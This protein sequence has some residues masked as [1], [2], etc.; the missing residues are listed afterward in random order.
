MTTGIQEYII[1]SAGILTCTSLTTCFYLQVVAMQ[2]DMQKQVAMMVAVRV[3]K[4]G[5][6]LE[7]SLGR[8]MEKAVKANA[9]ALWAHFQ[10]ENAKLEKAS[11]ERTQQLSNMISNCLNKDL[12]AILEK[13]VKKELN[14]VGQ[15]VARTITP[16]I[17]KTV[18]ASILET[19]Q[20]NIWIFLS[21]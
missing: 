1:P 2:K 6:R 8:I 15:A 20:V 10:E 3:T 14:A 21:F 5:R 7:A 13:A 19:F 18:S 16:S 9:D 17:E 11:W 4:E 12:P